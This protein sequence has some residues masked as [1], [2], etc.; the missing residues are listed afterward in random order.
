MIQNQIVGIIAPKGSGKTHLATKLQAQ[1]NRVAI[2]DLVGEPAW[3]EVCDDLVIGDPHEFGNAICGTM[4][5]VVYRPAIYDAETGACPEFDWFARLAFLRGE[6]TLVIDEAH[7]V[8]SP[9]VIPQPLKL[10]P[11]IG[12]HRQISLVYITQSFTAVHRSLT[13]STN[14]FAIFR[15]TDDL[16]LDGLARRCGR[17]VADLARNL[18]KLDAGRGV[19]GEIL[20]WSDLGQVDVVSADTFSLEIPQPASVELRDRRLGPG[21]VTSDGGQADS[22]DSGVLAGEIPGDSESPG[23][24]G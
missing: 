23:D 18:R 22:R 19:P 7:L 21:E 15:L 9:Q 13:R 24:L 1:F 11:L 2:F 4:Y 3:A 6:I 17:P 16:D 12:R 5:R 10:V 8:C 20:R 14:I